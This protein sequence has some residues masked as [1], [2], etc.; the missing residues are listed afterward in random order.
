MRALRWFWTRH[1]GKSAECKSMSKHQNQGGSG[2]DSAF[3]LGYTVGRNTSCTNTWRVAGFK[4]NNQA[5]N[6]RQ[7]GRRW[8]ERRELQ[9]GWIFQP[10]ELKQHFSK[11]S[12]KNRFEKSIGNI[13]QRAEN[14]PL[15]SDEKALTAARVLSDGITRKV[16]DDELAKMQHGAPRTENV[17]ISAIKIA[18]P[19]V[20]ERIFRYLIHLLGLPAGE[21][22]RE[23]KEGWVIPQ[24]KKGAKNALNNYRGVCLLSLASS[25]IAR[26][27]AS[28]LSRWAA[29]V[30]ILDK[31]Q[32]G[33]RS[34][35][36]TADA[37]QLI[38]RTDEESRRVLGLSRNKNER[39]PG[40][41]LPD[42]TKAYPRVNKPLL[43]K[44]LERLGIPERVMT[45]LIQSERTR[46]P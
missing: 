11:V 9:S 44:M 20:E 24:Q 2:S 42:S 31:N 28:R 17:K 18:S 27:F 4:F 19:Q 6:P 29:D 40:S 46:G 26:I 1:V 35:R 14:T 12:E 25:I 23:T 33:F 16:F 43:W 36:S 34:G 3:S 21:W 10:K 8:R 22:R 37:T 38:I 45:V 13:L 15:R 41:V 30:G 39:S 7:T 32:N 5:I